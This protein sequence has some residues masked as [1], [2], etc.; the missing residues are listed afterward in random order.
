VKIANLSRV[1]KED[2]TRMGDVPK[3]IDA[4]ISPVNQIIDV[5]G[6]A[7]SNNLTFK[8][9]FATAEVIQKFTHGVESQI[10]PHTTQKVKGIVIVDTGGEMI[11]GY[12]L[13]RKTTG[14]L[15]IT[16][17]YNAGAGT[18]STVTLYILNG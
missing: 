9:N 10:N 17:N 4:L 3:W 1:L 16:I 7:L 13:V 5:A 2:L 18:V 8:D 14:N 12:R 11:T 15:G 6:K